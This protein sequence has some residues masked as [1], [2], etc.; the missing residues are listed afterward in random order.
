M[1]GDLN[2]ALDNTSEMELLSLFTSEDVGID[3]VQVRNTIYL[4]ASYLGM[5]L[6]RYLTPVE[7]VR[8]LVHLKPAP[9]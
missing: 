8:K 7:A 2:V 9:D 5:F 6:E 3:Y 4:S 1:A